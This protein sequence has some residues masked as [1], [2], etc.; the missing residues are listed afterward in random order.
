MAMEKFRFG[1]LPIPPVEYSPEHLRQAFRILELYFDQLDSQTPRQAQSYRADRF[2]GGTFSGDFEG[3]DV[4][5]ANVTTD[6]LLASQAY[7]QAASINLISSF[8]ILTD[9]IRADRITAS[10]VSANNFYGNFFY[11][12][13]RFL[14]VPYNQFLSNVDQTAPDLD[15]RNAVSLEVTNFANG[16]YIAGAND[17]EI[18]FSEPGVYSITYSLSFKNT[19]NEGEYI[20]IWIEYNGTDYPDSNSRFFIPARKNNNDASYL[21]AVT[22]ITRLAQA[23]NDYVRIMWHPSNT[24]VI[25]EHLPAVTASAGVT[26]DIPATPSAIVQ[27]NFISAEYPPVKRVAPLPVFG[28]GQV[29]TVAV[30]TNLG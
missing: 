2:I 30:T 11:G 1:A 15:T 27:A 17:D 6:L 14:N 26:P 8:A 3:G 7:I 21:I 24:V 22:T 13:G 28:F 10:D 23:A 29:G 18:T 25:M 16:I 12:S 20:D 5:V 19:S 4:T 9:A